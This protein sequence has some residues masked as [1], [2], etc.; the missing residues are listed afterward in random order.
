MKLLFVIDADRDDGT[1]ESVTER[2][3]VIVRGL[4]GDAFVGLLDNEPAFA[5]GNDEAYLVRLAEV[6]FRPE[7]VIDKPPRRIAKQMLQATPTRRWPRH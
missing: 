6:P 7:H 5:E 1:A 4:A 2:M 3:W